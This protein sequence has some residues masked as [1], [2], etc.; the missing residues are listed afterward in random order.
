[1][2][3]RDLIRELDKQAQRIE[4]F[5][6]GSKQIWRVWNKGAS[7]RLLLLHGGSGSWTHWVRN[8]QELCKEHEIWALDIPGFGESDLPPQAIDANDLA[9]YVAQGMK[10]ILGVLPVQVMGFS[11][12]GLVA[13]FMATQ[14]PEIISRLILVGVPALGLTGTPLTLKGL[15]PQMTE[16][17][18]RDIYRHNLEV[19]MIADAKAIDESTL[20]MQRHNVQRDRLKR[21][22]IA[23]GDAMLELQKNWRCPVHAIWGELDALYLGRIDKVK[24]RLSNCDLRSFDVIPSA[25]HWVQYEAPNEFNRCVKKILNTN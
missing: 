23:R 20:E 12:G 5:P 13:G 22:R 7:H 8:I 3:D 15:R 9:P 1:M 10:E 11:F 16:D 24:D 2:D 17:E 14:F 4:L 21:R 18:T 6:M 19:M 25:G